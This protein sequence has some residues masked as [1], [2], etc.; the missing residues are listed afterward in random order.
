V[1]VY[2]NA[3]VYGNA[4]VYGELKLKGG[5][6][7]YYKEKTEQVEKVELDEDYELLAKDPKVERSEKTK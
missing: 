3:E 2:G 7:F 6:F 5:H 1:R 4:T